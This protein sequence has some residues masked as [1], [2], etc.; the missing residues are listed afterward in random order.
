M[1]FNGASLLTSAAMRFTGRSIRRHRPAAGPV[2]FSDCQART[3]LG[4]GVIV[5][6]AKDGRTV[7]VA[8]VEDANM[9][10]ANETSAGLEENGAAA[11][12]KIVA[13]VIPIRSGDMVRTS[14][15]Y[16]ISAVRSPA[17]FAPIDEQIVK[18]FVPGDA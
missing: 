9:S 6:I 12:G 8:V 11:S 2:N 3:A 10:R 15:A 16:F 7:R 14:H 13:V 17:T 5:M 18:I 4:G 1:K